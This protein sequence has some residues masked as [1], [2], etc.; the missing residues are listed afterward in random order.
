MKFYETNVL[1][2]R[3]SSSPI[4]IVEEGT[5]LSRVAVCSEMDAHHHVLVVDA[6][7]RIL[8]FV[9]TDEIRK[10]T[11]I[12]GHTERRRW[13]EMSIESL[14]PARLDQQPV[15]NV[16]SQNELMSCTP[17]IEDGQL[18][19]LITENDALISW[20]R[21]A[22]MLNRA[23]KDAVTGLPNRKAYERRLH[24]ELSRAR[25]V[26][27]SVSVV[28]IDVDWFKEINDEHGHCI[29]DTALRTVGEALTNTMRSYDFVARYGGDEFAAICFGCRPGETVIPIRRVQDRIANLEMDGVRRRLTLS[30]GAAVAHGG[31]QAW[32]AV[33]LINAADE[34][35]YRA[36]ESGRGCAYVTELKSPTDVVHPDRVWCMSE[37]ET[38]DTVLDF[39]CR[40]D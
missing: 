32:S 23:T 15:P 3:E 12:P 16:N 9:D 7:R 35:L 37:V 14:L 29:G 2:G 39:A 6:A 19:S 1:L 13:F 24:E 38:A 8:G 33:D 22:L 11:S 30:L 28:L 25:R 34:C 21:L 4:P 10:R 20:N 31:S 27:G 17:V 5:P 18:V 36:K 26:D 40:T